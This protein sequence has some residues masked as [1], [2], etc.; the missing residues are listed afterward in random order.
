MTAVNIHLPPETQ[1]I[2]KVRFPLQ[3]RMDQDNS[4]TLCNALSPYL[5]PI[6]VCTESHP[7]QHPVNGPPMHH[8]VSVSVV[9]VKN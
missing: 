7:L 9:A 3:N 1:H 8:W 4:S 5:T 6:I 2:H